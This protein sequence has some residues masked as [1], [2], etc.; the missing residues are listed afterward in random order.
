MAM[1]AKLEAV[2][3]IDHVVPTIFERVN[4]SHLLI[5]LKPLEERSK[6]QEQ[7]AMAARAA[8]TAYS[9]YR[10]TVLFKTPIGGGENNAWPILA[11][12][13]G[14]DLQKLSTIA[15]R[16]NDRLQSLPPFIDTKARVNLGNPELRVGVDRQRAA[17]LGVRVADLAVALRLMVSGEDEITSFRE[18]GERYP[19]K[20]R[21]REN[22]R[23]DVEAI[24][25]LMVASS[26]GNLV[27]IDNLA[28]LERGVGPT[29][30][31]RLDREFA[32][33]VSSDIRPGYALDNVIPM[34]ARRDQ[35]LKLP[36]DIA[37]SF[38]ASPKC[39]TRPPPT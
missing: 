24:G 10:P 9:A 37:R 6:S 29:S 4:H 20:I 5:G 14:P 30:I 28:R 8:M 11:F 34:V 35:K 27:R 18:D 3:G 25:S 13:Y 33:G 38:P 31:T 15:L 1:A 22:Q 19:V 36:P 21:V 7:I 2:E 39:W 17:D 26:G 32:V 16:L 12:F 23:N